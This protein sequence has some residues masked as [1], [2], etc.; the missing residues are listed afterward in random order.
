MEI[1]TLYLHYILRCIATG[2]CVDVCSEIDVDANAKCAYS[3][4][5]AYTQLD[6]CL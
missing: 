3:C 6:K 4:A 5:A 1:F 2:G